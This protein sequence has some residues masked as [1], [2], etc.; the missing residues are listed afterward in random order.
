MEPRDDIDRCFEFIIE[1]EK[2]KAVAR[3]TKPIGLDRYENSAEH[4]WQ[5]ALLA[6]ILAKHSEDAIDLEKVIK[7]LLIHDLG[8]IEAD[9]VFFFDEAG[10]AAAREAELRGIRSLFAILPEDTATELEALWLEFDGGDSPEARFARA[11][12]RVMPIL[13]NINNGRQSWIENGVTREQVLT[14]TAYIADG[15]SVVWESI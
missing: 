9:D 1:I 4:S 14:K 10:R 7:M 8:E 6:T 13:Q 2:L 3:R 11:V 12:D 5:I 15:S